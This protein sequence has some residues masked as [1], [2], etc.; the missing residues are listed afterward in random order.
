MPSNSGNCVVDRHENAENYHYRGELMCLNCYCVNC[1]CD[2]MKEAERI[3][4]E[5]GDGQ[6]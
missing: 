5:A 6:N 2:E 1:C 3:E 4:M